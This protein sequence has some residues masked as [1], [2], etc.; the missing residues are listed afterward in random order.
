MAKLTS[1]E[2]LMRV[3]R[4]IVG[5]RH[6]RVTVAMARYG[7]TRDDLQ[8]G[9]R[10]FH[11]AGGCLMT[12]EAREAEH[13]ETLRLLDNWENGWFPIA[14]A[15]LQRAF[16]VVHDVLFKN[17]SQ[18]TGPAVA[19]SVNSFINRLDLMAAGGEG[20]GAEGV[21]ARKMLEK[22]GLTAAVVDEA[23]SMLARL[24]ELPEVV[25][26]SPMAEKAQKA[27]ADLWAWFR[28]WGQ[29]A[30]TAVDDRN[31]LRILG[32]RKTKNGDKVVDVDEDESTEEET[33]PVAPAPLGA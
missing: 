3:A 8:E 4:F 28:D 2:R 16:P 33:A 18:T 29:V 32:Y 24:G 23:R 20:Y 31:L 9:W 10:L 1:N 17:L 11:E 27:E 12:P 7:F 21:E 26:T 6:P 19:F 5:V 13:D 14:Q 30:R 25:D 22:R 15:G